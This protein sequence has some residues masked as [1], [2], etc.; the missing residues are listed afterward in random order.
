MPIFPPLFAVFSRED[1]D[2]FLPGLTTFE[3]VL[4]PACLPTSDP[5][6]YLEQV[7]GDIRAVQWLLPLAGF[8]PRRGMWES[9]RPSRRPPSFFLAPFAT[10]LIILC[11]PCRAPI[12]C[13]QSPLVATPPLEYPRSSRLHITPDYVF[14]Q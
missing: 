1:P 12:G 14:S 7:T 13:C 6:S 5:I 2:F 3:K 9:K 4:F 8:F 11:W 10:H